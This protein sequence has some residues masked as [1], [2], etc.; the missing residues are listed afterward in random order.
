MQFVGA[1]SN[2]TSMGW[3]MNCQ[4][5]CPYVAGSDGGGG[6]WGLYD[7]GGGGGVKLPGGRT[8]VCSLYPPPPPPAA[9]AVA[10]I[11]APFRIILRVMVFMLRRVASTSLVLV[12]PPLVGVWGVPIKWSWVL[13]GQGQW[14]VVFQGG[15]RC[16]F[17]VLTSELPEVE[18]FLP[19]CAC[20]FT[21]CPM[22]TVFTEVKTA[23]TTQVTHKSHNTAML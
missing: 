15:R 4:F 10:V 20:Q 17:A 11:A 13:W 3:C 16:H 12:V 14:W 6:G 7:G 9:V 1:L 23:T 18:C 5:T 22:V 8:S 2:P 19:L 21:V